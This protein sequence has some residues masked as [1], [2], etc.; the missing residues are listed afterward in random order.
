MILIDTNILLRCYLLVSSALA[1]LKQDCEGLCIAPQNLVENRVVATRPA[2]NNGLGMQPAAAL[3]E[4]QRL[5]KGFHCWKGNGFLLRLWAATITALM[6]ETEQ[7][8]SEQRRPPGTNEVPKRP[9]DASRTDAM[10][11]DEKDVWTGPAK[12]RGKKSTQCANTDSRSKIWLAVAPVKC[13]T[14]NRIRSDAGGRLSY[15]P[16]VVGYFD[17]STVWLTSCHDGA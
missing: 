17:F 14:S 7:R 1:K 13:K 15:L 8:V 6:T 10:L 5:R 11:N 4:M 3:A 16:T 9:L 2:E 12:G